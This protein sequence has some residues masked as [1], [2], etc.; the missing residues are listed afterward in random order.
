MK[1]GR[2]S[3]KM[4]KHYIR[5]GFFNP[6]TMD[7]LDQMFLCCVKENYPVHCK[8]FSSIPG[9]NLLKFSCD[10]EKYQ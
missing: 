3:G 8:I 6:S 4:T 2:S 5:P 1:E 7:I 10:D 9:L